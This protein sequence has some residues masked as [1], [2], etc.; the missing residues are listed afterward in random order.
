MHST[1]FKEYRDTLYIHNNSQYT[2][3]SSKIRI[4]FTRMFVCTST[5]KHTGYCLQT[6]LSPTIHDARFFADFQQS[7]SDRLLWSKMVLNRLVSRLQ[8]HRC[9][10]RCTGAGLVGWKI[11][12]STV[13][14]HLDWVTKKWSAENK[15]VGCNLYWLATPGICSAEW[16]HVWVDIHWLL[17]AW[18]LIEMSRVFEKREPHLPG[19]P[20]TRGC[21]GRLVG[22]GS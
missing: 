8:L 14:E 3:I 22:L 9:Y 12:N 13:A 15:V 17:N 7:W 2:D 18:M 1:Y 10:F 4:I 21:N 11:W 19:M 20:D 16:L 6:F 5:L